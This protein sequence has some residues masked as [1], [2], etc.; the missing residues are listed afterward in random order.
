MTALDHRKVRPAD[1]DAI[2]IG[3]GLN[4][5]VCAFLLAQSRL[6]VLVLDARDRTGGYCATGEIIPGFRAPLYA[7]WI[8]PIDPA[9]VK[10]LKAQKS[11]LEIAQ[12]RLGAIALSPDGHHIYL[13]SHARRGTGGLARHSAT[14]ARTWAPFEAAMRKLASGLGPSVLEAPLRAGAK[15]A[16]PARTRPDDGVKA[17]LA[18]LAVRSIASVAEEYFESP[19]LQGALALEAIIGTGLGPRTPGSALSWIERLAP[20]TQ[21]HD[22]AMWVQGGPG[23][24][25]SALTQAAQAL[26]V[27]FRLNARVEDL[28]ASGGRAEAVVLAGGETLFAPLIVSSLSP[29]EVLAWH[30]ARRA[31]PLGLA[32]LA[33]GPRAPHGIAKVHFALRGLPQFK[34]LDPKD[35]RA[36]LVFADSID[37]VESAFDAAA[38]DAMPETFPMEA[39][40]PSAIDATLAPKDGHVM[41]VL[42]PFAPLSPPQGWREARNKLTLDT[43]AA[44]SRYAPDLPNRILSAEVET[45]ESLARIAS[46]EA[47]LWRRP[48]P[49]AVHDSHP[50]GCAIEGLFFCGAG[51][52]PRLGASGLNGRNCAEAILAL[53]PQ[54]AP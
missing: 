31:A 7:H 50:Y 5:L 34:G 42:V 17:T 22:T 3:A 29:A 11:G 39:T 44:L 45:P 1:A 26:G 35:L 2:V 8:G 49:A 20:D 15:G 43:I 47:M 32:E 18:S 48:G 10:A 40:I 54:E 6:R 33:K 19:R 27:A 13:D 24:L 12:P 21:R 23:A 53:Q 52:H 41:S 28:L 4:G 16:T 25:T 37:A 46:T 9:L 51:T 30:G 38:R 14:D 36:R